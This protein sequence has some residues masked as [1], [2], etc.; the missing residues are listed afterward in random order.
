[1]ANVIDLSGVINDDWVR[2]DR[3]R[4]MGGA[5]RLLVSA[6]DLAKY[7]G[8]LNAHRVELGLELEADDVIEGIV[9]W[10]PRLVLVC[11]NFSAFSDGRAFS[12]ARLLRERF[13][14]RG[15]SVPAEKCCAISFLS[16]S[17]VGSTNSGWPPM[18]IS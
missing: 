15:I 3:L 1:M 8:Y 18:K 10:L 12:Q 14:Y 13:A 17:A 16:C 5:R 6:K 4:C 7:P 2:Y 11:I 9:S